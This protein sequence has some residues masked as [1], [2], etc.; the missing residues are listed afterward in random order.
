MAE[1]R[2][3]GWGGREGGREGGR[4]ERTIIEDQ[5]IKTLPYPLPPSLPPLHQQMDNDVGRTVYA[6]A[7]RLNM[8]VGLMLFELILLPSLPLSLPP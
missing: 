4:K 7:G 5:K 1:W 8:P 6:E 2:E 3:G